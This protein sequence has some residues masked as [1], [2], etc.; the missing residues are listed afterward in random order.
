MNRIVLTLLLITYL[1]SIFGNNDHVLSQAELALSKKEFQT[2]LALYKQIEQ[3]GEGGA[4]MYQ[5][6]ALASAALHDDASAI[7]YLEKAQKYAPNNP[8]IHENLISILK[9]N[10]Q[11]DNSTSIH[12]FKNYINKVTGVLSIQNWIILS[13]LILI[14]IGGMIYF[15]FPAISEHKKSTYIIT[16]L[17]VLFILSTSA[18]YYRHQNIYHNRGIIITQKDTMLK[19]GPDE[20]SPEVTYLPQGSKVS[21]VEH[22]NGWWM[23]ETNYGDKGWIPTTA[24]QRI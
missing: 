4:G 16:G 10:S 19:L 11:L 14:S 18:G 3:D 13:L 9:R 7:L 1:S 12:V 2:A 15:N 22:L 23:V 21:Y 8:K 5:N 20:A 6:M 17:S 24:G